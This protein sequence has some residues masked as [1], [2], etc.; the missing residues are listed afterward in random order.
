M[1]SPKWSLDGK[2]IAALTLAQKTVMLYDTTAGTWKALGSIP[3]DHPS[4][5]NDS[6]SIYFRAYLVDQK[7]ICRVSVPDGRVE[8][9]S[10]LRNFHA[11]SILL[12]EFAGVTPDGAP[13]M[14]AQISSGNLYTLN[15]SQQH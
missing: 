5:A 12:A 14:H 13:L 11:G 1:Y 4:W 6:R 7:P 9:I 8:Q 2:Y 3:A 10:D 15:L